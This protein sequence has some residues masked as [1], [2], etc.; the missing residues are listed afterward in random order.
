MTVKQRRNILWGIFLAGLGLLLLAGC[1]TPRE[2]Y[3]ALSFFFDGVP[4]PDAVKPAAGGGGGGAAVVVMARRVT[5]HKP[6][7]DNEC[8]ACHRSASGEI[9]EFSEA[10]KTCMKCHAKVAGG[11]VLMHGPVAREACQWC[12]TPHES[13]EPA[14]LRDAPLK[15]CTQCHDR[16]LLGDKPP[17][18]VDGKTSCLQCHFG[19]GGD[20]R[21]FLKPGAV[22]MGMPREG[23]PHRHAFEADFAGD[24]AFKIENAFRGELVLTASKAWHPAVSLGAPREDAPH[25]H[26]FEAD[27]AGDAAIKIENAFR[28]EPALTASKAW[29]PAGLGPDCR[30]FERGVL[31]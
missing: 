5:Q 17:E 4:D 24:A 14:L 15:V 31:V 18:H 1:G 23:T 20:G 13:A 10:Y 29:H 19:H 8:A 3:R 26:A 22:S 2:R 16:E 9:Q 27:F 6:Y 21:Y 7:A 12:H 28:G 25:G 30:W 11:H